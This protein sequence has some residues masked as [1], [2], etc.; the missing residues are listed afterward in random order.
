MVGGAQHVISVSNLLRAN[1]FERATRLWATSPIIAIRRPSR[2]PFFSLIVNRSRSA[3][4][5][6]SWAPSPALT[7]EESRTPES[8]CG[9]PA[10]LC[11]MMTASGRIDSRFLAVSLSVSPLTALLV[12]ADMLIVSAE[13]RLAAISKETRVLVLGS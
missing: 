13:R 10:M 5:G 7:T 11:R 6:C 1:I 4:V 12:L 3:W 2:V 8:M 9:A